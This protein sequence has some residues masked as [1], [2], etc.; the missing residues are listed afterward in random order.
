MRFDNSF[1]SGVEVIRMG[2][3]IHGPGNFHFIYLRRL[4]TKKKFLS[5]GSDPT[6]TVEMN[7]RFL[8]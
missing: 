3:F 4:K 2:A 6:T 1:V 8:N 7:R 5:N